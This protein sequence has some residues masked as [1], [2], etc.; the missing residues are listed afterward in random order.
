MSKGHVTQVMGPVVDVR[1]DDDKLPEIYNALTVQLEEANGGGTLTLEVAL[2]LGDNSVRTIAMASTDGLKR[3]MEVENLGRPISVPVGEVTLGRVFNVLGDKIDLDPDLP[4]GIRL[5]PIHRPA[6]KFEEL[7]TETEILETGIK[8]VDLLAP[9]IKGGKIGLF[10]GAGVGKTVLIQELINNIAQEHGG[11]S[12]FAGVGERTREGNDLYYEMKDSG[13]IAKTAMV[14]G[15][16]NEPPG[17]RMR[18]AL[19][20]LTMAEYFRDEQGADVLLFIDNIFRFTQAGSE[21]SALLGRMPSAVG[22]QPTLAT[23]MGQ[24]Q[25]RITSTNKGSVTSIQ[26]IYVPADDYTD[27]APAT[28]FAHLDAT[29]NLDR[30]L[31]EQGIYPAVDPL[32]STSRALDPEIVGQEH[33]EVAREVQATLQKYRELQ[34]IIAILG[35]DELSDDDKLTVA[36][37][38][39]IQFFLSQNFHVAE[40]F[41][42]QPGSY[43]PVKETVKGFKEILEG[44][45]DDLPEDAFRLVGRIE[46]VVEKAK[47]ME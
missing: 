47:S 35:M 8:V 39:R 45:Y 13:V 16:M 26:A 42:G 30:K 34:D 3:G 40:Q 37:A 41:T 21:V 10:G 4:E 20:G 23:E 36:R 11:I 2:H 7:S 29:T 31:S 44:K 9:Y 12:V 24:L 6:P 32:A 43:V 25:E 18:V 33:Y 15:Q 17:A 1:F 27:P 19:T 38:R 22:Y 5:D 46:E 28:T 14:F